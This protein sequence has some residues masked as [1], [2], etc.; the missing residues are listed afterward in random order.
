MNSD[1][2]DLLRLFDEEKV[3]YLVIGGYAVIRYTEPRYTKD[4]DLLLEPTIENAAKVLE[5]LRKFGAPLYDLG[6]NDLIAAGT[7]YQIGVVP[8]RIDL[9][10]KVPGVD[11]VSAYAN[12]ENAVVD[13]IS[14]P[15][16]CCD[17]LISAK[18]AS[19]RPQDLVDA[20]ALYKSKLNKPN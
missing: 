17:D 4:I 7:F 14:I 19:G 20:G 3:K 16:I 2:K 10:V 9:I 8:N 15:F 1:F 18:L 11:F 6:V 12:R 5:C 13:G